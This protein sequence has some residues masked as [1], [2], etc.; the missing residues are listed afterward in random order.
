M[1]SGLRGCGIGGGE[2]TKLGGASIQ[3][4]ISQVT[5]ETLSSRAGATVI[6]SNS[7]QEVALGNLFNISFVTR[8]EVPMLD[9]DLDQEAGEEAK[10]RQVEPGGMEELRS[11]GSIFASRKT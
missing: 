11:E 7:S 8:E 10:A 4:K 9:S 3:P 2:E 6:Y 1:E 5:R